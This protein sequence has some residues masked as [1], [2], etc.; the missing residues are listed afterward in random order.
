M[1]SDGYADEECAAYDV[2]TGQVTSQPC[3]TPLPMVC[4]Q[5]TLPAN[6]STLVFNLPDQVGEYFCPP[7]WITHVLAMDSNLC[8]KRFTMPEAVTWDEAREEC[9]RQGGDLSMA[10]TH[11]LRIAMEMVYM[12]FNNQSIVDSWIGARNPGGRPG[13]LRWANETIDTPPSE[14]YVWQP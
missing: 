5:P 2:K 12:F 1:R 14:T 4:G 9:I 6:I 11:S 8:Y 10:P 7:G 13:V 3:K